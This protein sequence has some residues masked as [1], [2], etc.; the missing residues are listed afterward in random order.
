MIKLVLLDV[1]GTLTDRKRLIS[2]RAIEAIRN[3][4]KEGVV[5][6][7]ASGNVIPVMYGLKILLGINGPV[8]GENGGVK[9]QDKTEAFFSID[10]PNE[11]FERLLQEGKVEGILSNR[12]RETSCGY[13]PASGSE[14]YVTSVAESEGLETVDSGYS[15]HLL[16][17]GQNKGYALDH[18]R[19]LYELDYGEIA[20]MGDSFNDLSMFRK[21]VF[22]AV[23]ANAEEELK[24]IADFI[25]ESD[26]GDGVVELLSSLRGSKV[27]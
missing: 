17:K 4:Q 8:F 22:K 2:T 7:L 19:D 24:E 11:V 10:K 5:V 20:V 27:P 25:S 15:W 9:Y 18:L 6:S 16:N 26:D 12:W 13:V 21:G 23:P 14:D 3:V 1:D